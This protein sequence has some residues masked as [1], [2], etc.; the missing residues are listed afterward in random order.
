MR[1]GRRRVRRNGTRRKRRNGSIS[2]ETATDGTNAAGGID[3]G[4]ETHLMSEKG[5]TGIDIGQGQGHR[6]GGITTIGMATDEAT[7][8]SS[9]I[10]Q[11]NERSVIYARIGRGRGRRTAK[12]AKIGTA[13]TSVH[14]HDRHVGK[15]AANPVKT[16]GSELGPHIERVIRTAPAAI[17]RNLDHSQQLNL[18]P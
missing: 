12:I 4:L 1:R 6:E 13:T 11:T 5:D 8:L 17:V 15:N 16:T 7:S 2:I 9:E 3:H 14:G 18:K 10:H